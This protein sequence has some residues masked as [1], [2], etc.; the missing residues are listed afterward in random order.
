MARRTFRFSWSIAAL[1]AGL[2][3]GASSARAADGN[4]SVD[5]IQAAAPKDTLVFSADHVKAPVPHCRVEGFVAVD[6]PGPNRNY[7]RLQLP[8]RELW[9]GRF[10]F[11][12]LGGAAVVTAYQ[13]AER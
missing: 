4:C 10:Y 9:K 3:A 7:F 2:I 11:I 8:D 5:F 6:S 1:A 13:R 12:G